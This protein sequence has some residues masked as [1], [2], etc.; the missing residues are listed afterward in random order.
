MKNRSTKHINL[1]FALGCLAF[2]SEMEAVL[3]PDG[4]YPGNNTAEGQNA[5]LSLTAG[6]FNPSL[7]AFDK[8]RQPY[9]YA[10]TK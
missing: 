5:L 9:S 3:P 2:F 6:S 1:L 10:T 4:G 7:V 8:E